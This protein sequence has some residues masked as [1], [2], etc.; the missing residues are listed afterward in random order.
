MR[1]LIPFLIRHGYP[2]LFFW[3][4]AESA[5]LPIPSFP[6]LITVGALAG[7]GRMRLFPCIA[8]GVFAAL[9]SDL[10]WYYAGRVRGGCLL[11]L[12]C[13]I[14]LEPD[15]CVRQTEGLFSRYGARSLLVAKFVPGLSAVSTPLAGVIHMRLPLF[16]GY[17]GAGAVLWIGSF[18][19]LGYL[20][21]EEF[22]RATLYAASM[23]R[24]LFVAGAG[25][26]SG[27]VLRKYYLRR[28]FIKELAVARI[29]AEE[30]KRK[31]DAGEEVTIVDVRHPLDFAADPYLIPGSL[32]IASEALDGLPPLPKERE[33]VVYCT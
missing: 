20:F 8:L 26:L 28:R 12:L 27:Y 4:L 17:D 10:F 30:L 23:G 5:G 6:L 19:L 9:I 13:R 14:S 1:N 29:S 32:R 16:L 33:V 21:G 25:G 7:M 24:A 11:S 15:S 31:L 22:D 3:V 2:L 18:T